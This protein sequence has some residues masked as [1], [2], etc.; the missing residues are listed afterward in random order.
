MGRREAPLQAAV[1]VLAA[2]NIVASYATGD[3]RNAEDAVKIVAAAIQ[4]CV[5]PYQDPSPCSVAESLK[6]RGVGGSGSAASTLSSTTPPA[7]S[8]C[9]LRICAPRA[10]RPS[11]RLTPLVRSSR[12]VFKKRIGSQKKNGIWVCVK[13]GSGWSSGSGPGPG[14]RSGS[15]S[16]SRE[17]PTARTGSGPG[18]GSG[19]GSGLV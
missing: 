9:R 15:R 5:P 4:K 8:S 7:T 2:E 10:S 1:S 13:A 19:S 12:T 6:P 3:V 14:S 18:P 16:G 11:S 17:S